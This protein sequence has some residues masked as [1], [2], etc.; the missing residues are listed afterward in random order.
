MPK[1]ALSYVYFT[2]ILCIFLIES[3]QNVYRVPIAGLSGD[4]RVIQQ[5]ISKG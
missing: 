3:I 5:G 1:P 4:Y 2:H